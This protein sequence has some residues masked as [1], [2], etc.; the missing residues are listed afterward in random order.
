MSNSKHFHYTRYITALGSSLD[1][2]EF[3]AIRED[4]IRHIAVP[5]GYY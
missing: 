4:T 5:T 2:K 3:P 1:S